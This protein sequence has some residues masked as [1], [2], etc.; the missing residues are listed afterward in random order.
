MTRYQVPVRINVMDPPGGVAMQVQKG[1]DELVPPSEETNERLV[2]DMVIDVQIE[3]GAPNFLGK[4][5]Q[6]P[7][8][9][10]FIYLNSGTYAGQSDTQWSRRAKISLMDVT[11]KQVRELLSSPGARLEISIRGTGTDG[12]PVCASI[13]RANTSGWRVTT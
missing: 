11:V 4:F 7:K 5:A 1:R 9:S 13:K 2:F 10:R 12:G 8:Q 3:S 6:G